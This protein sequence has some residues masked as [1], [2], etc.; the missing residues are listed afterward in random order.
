MYFNT[1]F[2]LNGGAKLAL[3]GDTVCCRYYCLKLY[4]F[5]GV[6]SR[7]PDAMYRC[8]IVIIQFRRTVLYTIPDKRCIGADSHLLYRMNFFVI[9]TISSFLE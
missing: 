1:K 8:Q 7:D 5:S 2:A 9:I 4:L 3:I 6:T